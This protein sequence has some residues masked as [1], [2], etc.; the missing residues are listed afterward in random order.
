MGTDAQ[1]IDTER[2][3]RVVKQVVE[4]VDSRGFIHHGEL[5]DNIMDNRRISESDEPLL[6]GA[7]DAAVALAKI[8]EIKFRTPLSTEVKTIYSS[9]ASTVVEMNGLD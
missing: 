3:D 8:G 6:Y 2:L 4:V 1:K 9:K 5:I 7:I